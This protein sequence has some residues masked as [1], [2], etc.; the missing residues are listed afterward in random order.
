ME[1]G[2]NGEPARGGSASPLAGVGAGGGG[3]GMASGEGVDM[4]VSILPGGDMDM[5]RELET[6]RA[7]RLWGRGCSRR[8]TERAE[9]SLTS[10]TDALGIS[11]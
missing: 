7:A 4:M 2:I 3:G 5:Q 10:H 9:T 1:R 8:R 6:K 11:G